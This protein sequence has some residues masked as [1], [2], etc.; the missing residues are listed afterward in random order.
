MSI[1]S[2]GSD[3]VII[4]NGSRGS[5]FKELIFNLLKEAK[6]KMHY[7]NILLDD[8]SIAFYSKAFTSDTADIE[9]NYEVFEQLG[10]ISANKFLV[11]YMHRRFPKLMCSQGVKVVARLRINY[12]AK[13]SFSSIAENLG[14]WNFI[15]A[16]EEE[17]SRCKKPLLEDTFE[18]FIGATEYLIDTK[19][20]ECVGYSVVYNILESL[21]DKIHISLK[22]EDLYDAKTRLKELFDFYGADVLG[23]LK[24]DSVK[25]IEEKI[26]CSTITQEFGRKKEILGEGMASLKADSEQKAAAKAIE[27]LRRKGFS[28]PVPP[29]YSF[30]S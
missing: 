29:I 24:Y 13:Q 26:T 16:S 28:K 11:W 21:F 14:F 25:N 15:T 27:N 9:K 30:F 19:I 4:Y 22:Y 5:D 1:R 17:R 23:I 18:A 10:D 7:I 3:E 2:T 20:R 12:G 6:L 8:D